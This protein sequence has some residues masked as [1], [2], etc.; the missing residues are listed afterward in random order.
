MNILFIILIF[1]FVSIILAV[2][3]AKEELSIP[4]SIKNIKIKRKKGISGAIVFLKEK[5]SHYSSDSS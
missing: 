5:I 3:D 4:N 2:R 1:I